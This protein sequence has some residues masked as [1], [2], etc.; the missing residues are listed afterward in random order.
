VLDEA[1]DFFQQFIRAEYEMATAAYGE[2]DTGLYVEK[3]A[4]FERF[5]KDVKT[6]DSRG[7]D[8]DDFTLELMA[9]EGEDWFETGKKVLEALRPRTLFQVKHYIHPEWGDLFR[10]Y[11]SHPR[12]PIVNVYGFNFYATRIDDELRI[13][14]MYST[15]DECFTTGKIKGKPCRECGATGWRFQEGRRIETPGRLVEVRK[16]QPPADPEQLR[17]YEAE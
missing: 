17:E 8:L 13:I 9:A 14:S 12:A 16:L 3:Y 1:V 15:C 4:E 11:L 7:R 10:G 6:M 2:R 5:L